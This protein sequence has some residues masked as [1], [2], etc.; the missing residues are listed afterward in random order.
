[1]HLAM[2][3]EPRLTEAFRTALE[4][5]PDIDVER[6]AYGSHPHWDA[7]GHMALVAEIEDAYGVMLEPADVRALSSY[8]KAVELVERAGAR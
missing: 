4:L 2:A 7:V 6:L 8:A 3:A 1:M 5:S